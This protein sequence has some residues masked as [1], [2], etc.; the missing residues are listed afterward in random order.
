MGIKALVQVKKNRITGRER[1]VIIPIYHSFGIDDIGSC[2]EF[3]L[4]EGDWEK[5]GASIKVP[6]LAFG[7][8]LK[9]TRETII[10]KIEENGWEKDLIACV[11]DVWTAL[12]MALKINRKQRYE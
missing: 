8:A 10:K 4:E 5:K 1:E 3:M 6:E 11:E 12:E 2:V 9:G 7:E